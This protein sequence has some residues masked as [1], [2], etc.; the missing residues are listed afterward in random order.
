MKKEYKLLKKVSEVQGISGDEKEVAMLIKDELK[1]IATFEYD[2]LGST[3]AYLNKDSD[4][5]KV[6]LTAHMDEVGFI[7]SNITP[8]GFIYAPGIL[9]PITKSPESFIIHPAREIRHAIIMAA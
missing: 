2:N 6:L 9:D 8:E 7:V 4:L 3:I 5:P 1:D